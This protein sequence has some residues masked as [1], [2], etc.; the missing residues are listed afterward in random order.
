[1]NGI[2]DKGRGTPLVLIPGLQGRWEWMRPTVDALAEHHRVLTFSLCDERSSQFPCDP[3]KGFDN[4]V[5]QER[6][7]SIAQASRKP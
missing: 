5:E 4:F 7:R 2:V 6:L 3:A 1:M